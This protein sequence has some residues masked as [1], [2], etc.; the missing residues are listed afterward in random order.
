MNA[1]R[2]DDKFSLLGPSSAVDGHVLGGSM[3]AVTFVSL[4]SLPPSAAT[5]GPTSTSVVGSMFSTSFG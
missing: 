2:I 1:P 5:E 3:V 4:A